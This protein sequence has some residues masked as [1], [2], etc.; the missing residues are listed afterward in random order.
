MDNAIFKQNDAGQVKSNATKSDTLINKLQ[1]KQK[2]LK[3]EWTSKTNRAK[4]ISGLQTEQEPGWHKVLN[5]VFAETNKP[6]GRSRTAATSKMERFGI[7][8][9]GSSR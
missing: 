1:Q 4:S 6:R 7:I 9:N 8:V 2:R 5:Q 3:Q